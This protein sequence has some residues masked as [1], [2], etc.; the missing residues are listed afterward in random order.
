MAAT[1]LGKLDQANLG[2]VFTY[3]EAALVLW[4]A[5]KTV[6]NLVCKHRIPT[7]VMVIQ[8]ARGRHKTYRTV[9]DRDGLRR[10]KELI[11]GEHSFTGRR[12]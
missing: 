9:I 6:R 5:P 10:L 2:V 12:S 1:G 8:R 11:H 4:R 7:Q 3:R